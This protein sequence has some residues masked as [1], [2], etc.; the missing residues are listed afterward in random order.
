MNGKE[1]NEDFVEIK[2]W[3]LR[4]SLLFNYGEEEWRRFQRI[5][6]SWWKEEI[7]L[8]LTREN[9]TDLY[10]T[11]SLKNMP[12]NNNNNNVKKQHK[13]IK[14]LIH[15]HIRI[16]PI[17]YHINKPLACLMTDQP[18]Q[19]LCVLYPSLLEV[20]LAYRPCFGSTTLREPR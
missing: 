16:L 4:G 9:I 14:V 1:W 12:Y 18:H 5:V 15:I 19:L 6:S 17:I 11:M 20:E 7:F 10:L 8:A 13:L 3:T 2:E